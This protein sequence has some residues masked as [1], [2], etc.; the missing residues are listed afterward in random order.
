MRITVYLLI[1]K[2]VSVEL[3]ISVSFL[4]WLLLLFLLLLLLLLLLL[5]AVSEYHSTAR[6]EILNVSACLQASRSTTSRS[7]RTLP[8]HLRVTSTYSPC[9]AH[10][11]PIPVLDSNWTCLIPELLLEL[12]KPPK[13]SSSFAIHLLTKPLLH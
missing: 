13:I 3:L 7:C 2:L 12:T 8:F 9:V 6:K 10:F 1:W 11:G 5:V 4:D